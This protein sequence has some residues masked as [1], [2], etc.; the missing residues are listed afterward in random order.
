[1]SLVKERLR[2]EGHEG[3]GLEDLTQQILDAAAQRLVFLVGLESDQVGF[4]I[5][6]LQE[7]MAAESLMEGSDQDVQRRLLE[8]AP[9][10]NWRNVFLFA[11]GKCFGERQHL[12]DTV[13]S[14]CATLNETDGDEVAG[15]YLV[16]SGLAMD[17]LDDGLS[18]HQPKFVHSLARIAIRALDVPND[19]FQIQLANVYED[20]FAVYLCGGISPP[21]ERRERERK[22]RHLELSNT[23][24]GAGC[25]MGTT[26]R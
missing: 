14:I 8:I 4:E 19:S 21:S 26:A 2:E 25:R 23:S 17:L 7:F 24:C 16:G 11:S 5:R 12:R 6:S 9:L 3:R 1:M 20:Q 15:N 18:R 22:T 10:P 13:H